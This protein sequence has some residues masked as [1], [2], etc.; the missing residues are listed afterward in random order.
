[1]SPLLFGGISDFKE[2][3]SFYH[4]ILHRFTEL[5][6]MLFF[7]VLCQVWLLQ[8]MKKIHISFPMHYSSCV[9]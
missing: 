4:Y 1:M 6:L 8:V 9:I 2:I 7:C 3:D 5:G